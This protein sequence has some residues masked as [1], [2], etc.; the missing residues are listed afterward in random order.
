MVR[1]GS[2]SSE[3]QRRALNSAGSSAM[4]LGCSRLPNVDLQSAIVH[5]RLEREAVRDANLKAVITCGSC[6]ITAAFMYGITNT[7]L[8]P[9]AYFTVF[10]RLWVLLE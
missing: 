1:K 10:A 7:V 4:V 8:T 6:G 5:F 3:R 2:G 9:G